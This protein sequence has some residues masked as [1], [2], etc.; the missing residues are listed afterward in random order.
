[1]QV[2]KKKIQKNILM[3]EPTTTN[4]TIQPTP[5][6]KMPTSDETA[7]D[8]T[9]S[10]YV[11][12]PGDNEDANAT[13][14]S[15]Q[16]IPA[17]SPP[18][19][20]K[21]R[22][23]TEFYWTWAKFQK[24]LGH[25]K[26]STQTPDPV[27]KTKSCMCI[28]PTHPVRVVAIKIAHHWAFDAFI[29]SLI[30]INCIFMIIG[31]PYAPC[32]RAGETIAEGG[33]VVSS[34]AEMQDGC[35]LDGSTALAAATSFRSFDERNETECAKEAAAAKTTFAL[36]QGKC[37]NTGF[38]LW[39]ATETKDDRHPDHPAH[40]VTDYYWPWQATKAQ[41]CIPLGW[42]KTNGIYTSQKPD[43][44]P[45]DGP[46][47]KD[48][49][50]QLCAGTD[51]LDVSKVADI[52]FTVAFTFEMV[53]KIIAMGFIMSKGDES[54]HMPGA[55]LRDTWNW[56]DFIVVIA[57]Y[58]ELTGLGA[59]IS[60]LRTFR[61]LRPLRALNKAPSMK[62]LVRSLLRSLAP[63]VYVLL[64]MVFVLLLWGIVGTQLWNGLLHGTC[65]Y[66]DP[67]DVENADASG[68]VTDPGQ[69]GILCG[70]DYI[71]VDHATYS[72]RIKLGADP[73]EKLSGEEYDYISNLFYVGLDKNSLIDGKEWHNMFDNST[74]VA[75]IN[76]AKGNARTCE[77]RVY[78][79]QVWSTNITATVTLVDGG[80]RE[81]ASMMCRYGPNPNF[82]L[83]SF[84]NLGNAVLWIFASITLEG[85]VDS[86][87]NV[88]QVW[89]YSSPFMSFFVEGVYFTFLYLIGSMFMLN[90]TLA[91]IW[92][93]FENERER[94]EADED[95]LISQELH[96]LQLKNIEVQDREEAERVV[97]AERR[98]TAK[99][100]EETGDP[101]PDPW[102]PACIRNTWYLLAINKWF[103]MF[104][105]IAILVNT[106]TMG[107][108]YHNWQLYRSTYNYDTTLNLQNR[109][110]GEA[111][112]QPQALTGFLEVANYIFT[113]IF[114]FEMVVKMIGL[115]IPE[116]WKDNFNR[117]DF[118]IVM[119]SIVELILGIMDIQ[120]VSGL[121][122]LRS[123][124]LLRVLKLA[125]SWT[126]L[127]DLLITI[128]ASLVDVTVAAALAL[129]MMFI[130]TLLGMS[131][132]GGK[133][134]E[135]TFGSADDVPRA[136]FDD[137]FTGFMAVFQVLTGENW[138]DLL[139]ASYKTS[140]IVGWGYFMALTFIG[141]YMI[142]NLF[143][144]ILLAKFEE[145]GD[146]A[147][148]DAEDL[149]REAEEAAEAQ[150]L[151]GAANVAQEGK[152]EEKSEEKP[153]VIKPNSPGNPNS[154]KV[155]PLSQLNNDDAAMSFSE[156]DEDF[157]QPDIKEDVLVCNGKSLF[158]LTPDNK[159]RQMCFALAGNKTFDQLILML[160]IVSSIFLAMD[161]PWVAGCACYDVNDIETHSESCTSTI[162]LSWV[163]YFSAGNSMGYYMFLLW[164]DLIITI[165][166]TF[167][168]VLKIIAFG[169][170]FHKHAYL[171]NGWNVLD[172]AIVMVSLI[173]LATGPLAAGKICGV[174]A[175][176]SAL[177][178]L[179]AL[180]A[181]RALRPLRVIKRDPGLRLVINSLFQAAESIG[182]V[183]LVT[184]LFMMILA[185]LGQQFFV[186]TVATCNDGDMATFPECIGSFNV[187]GTDCGMLPHQRLPTTFTAEEW[188]TFANS[189][190]TPQF[191]LDSVTQ[192]ELNG[193]VGSPFPRIWDS[194]PVNFDGFGHSLT[195]V[196]EVASG[197]MWP[198]IMVTTIDARGIG[199]QPLPNSYQHGPF[200]WYFM[201]QFM[202]AF[203]MLNVFIGVIIEEYNKNKDA[204][205]GSGILTNDQKIWVETMKLAMNSKA[206]KKLYP[207]VRFKNLR[208]PSFKL[209]TKPQFDYFIMACIM[210]N[211]MFMGSSHYNQPIV[212]HDLL[213]GANLLFNI[214]FS[215][216]MILKWIGIGKQYF[217]DSW[218]LFDCFL[219][220]L[221]WIAQTG[222]LPPSLASLF[223]IFRVARM[224][225]LVRNVTGL[226][227]L[228]KTLIFS[229]P[230]LKNV[231]IIMILFMF[232]FSCFAMNT[233]GNIKHGELLTGD[234]NFETFFLAFNTMW[235]LSSGESYN[236]LMH[237]INIAVPYCNPNHGGTVSPTESNCGNEFWAFL[238]MQVSFTVLNYILVNLF[239]AIILDNFSEQCSMSE[240]K[241]TAEIL[242]DFDEVWASF[243]SKGTGKISEIRLPD[244]LLKIEYP[245][246]LKNVPVEHLHGKSLRKFRNQ[247]IQKLEISA[248]D[249][250]ITFVQTKKALTAAA[251]DD[252]EWDAEA[253]NSL[254][255]KNLDKQAKAVDAK[256]V[257]AARI[258][259]VGVSG[260]GSTR[261]LTNGNTVGFYN[262]S[263]ISA[264]KSIQSALRGYLNRKNLEMLKAKW[265]A[266][267]KLAQTVS[268]KQEMGA[269]GEGM[270]SME[271]SK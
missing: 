256:I 222:A 180:R 179:R 79:S 141:N 192:C 26:N 147:E 78:G 120:G 84:D 201:V 7:V 255:M 66:Y 168:M 27:Y 42:A 217:Y 169:F 45:K 103:G 270:T 49:Q 189:K 152:T 186:G 224:V 246:G 74:T 209:V 91:V 202:I 265:L 128:M 99:R 211:V 51:V 226:L 140:G 182:T 85:W 82:D 233:F 9:S 75:R 205:E 206:K 92:E 23:S 145:G 30:L 221:S 238:I 157:D 146:E 100:A 130:F 203:V 235:R 36:G 181:F 228:F 71:P 178:A 81:I 76:A 24:H 153:E 46:P 70:L 259:S 266:H 187:S 269:P 88:N 32:C 57:A 40:F 8:V 173:A 267:I 2:C 114:I 134:N 64:L 73:L 41:C 142:F 204:S 97:R 229:I 90:L 143:L 33:A 242:E 251:M 232:I 50:P 148:I 138:N 257:K 123:F 249:G 194:L 93:E 210:I 216:E 72:E 106:I 58:V 215:I 10:R 188:A 247:M 197:E 196:F 231:A 118:T 5:I 200:L 28:A 144:A 165:V 52:I 37:E 220:A 20:K 149:A 131:F 96:L 86:M 164:S 38:T 121:S 219:V 191:V 163:G 190:Y 177:K 87:Y 199:Q 185:I 234:A 254:M 239:I 124:R 43:S 155:L 167:E 105:T 133:W 3:T 83:S 126:S 248:L 225:R 21:E 59:G 56:L 17:S 253:S 162:P 18:S 243:D 151:L 237:D 61:V 55:Y 67:F 261:R 154:A 94:Q 260:A 25:V 16:K 250:F 115:S 15:L 230:A 125:K 6:E 98:A 11:A 53:V 252:V 54:K 108:E 22:E 117:F 223:R 4:N 80:T 240:S 132:F 39:R 139:W 14:D 262:V 214:I 264:A 35:A 218:N 195:T 89:S 127:Q 129:L 113:F 159:F 65:Q 258:S 244:M 19:K 62:M 271:I 77:D 12:T 176:G 29:L 174:A 212:M 161:E 170:A 44:Y 156:L 184:L 208:M 110:N 107:L 95:E 158:L 60:V 109:L 183:M 236:G 207:P 171:R 150:N 263:H 48:L 135:E 101:V 104:I 193:D 112:S 245:L 137:F 213:T 1:V 268:A 241:V 122:V 160:I 34:W 111:L 68:F 102:G 172:F 47:E 31:S 69:D 175:G 13:Q 63:M 119:F 116:Y 227:N 198:D 136:N 166:F